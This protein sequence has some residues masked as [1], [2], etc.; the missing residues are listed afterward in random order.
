MKKLI[1][2]ILSIL[3]IL[4]IVY[5]IYKFFIDCERVN[6]N[7]GRNFILSKMDY[8][9]IDDEAIVKLLDIEDNRCL[10]DTC[11]REGQLVVKLLVLNDMRVSYITLGTL[12]ESN[13]DIEKL[14]YSIE[15]VEASESFATIK[16]N[17]LEG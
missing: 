4:A 17:R 6:T 10:E 5:G 1:G 3:I 16:L 11:E 8:A 14:K 2:F 9:S 13:K 12:S 7:F 15:L